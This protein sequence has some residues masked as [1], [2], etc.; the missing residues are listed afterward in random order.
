MGAGRTPAATTSFALAVLPDTQ[1]YSRYATTDESQQFQRKYGSTPFDAQTRWI[2]DNAAA[3]N[4][5]S[6]CIWATWSTRSA[7]PTNGRSPTRR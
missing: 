3:Y 7:S 6:S 2:A 1:F 5:P 4:I